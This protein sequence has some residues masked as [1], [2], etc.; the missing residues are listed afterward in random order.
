MAGTSRTNMEAFYGELSG[1]VAS[2]WGEDNMAT[3]DDKLHWNS[4]STWFSGFSHNNT[5]SRT[6]TM[7]DTSGKVAMWDVDNE[8]V[9]RYVSLDYRSIAAV[10][11]PITGTWVT[12]FTNKW[13]DIIGQGLQCWIPIQLPD[14][15]TITRFCVYSQEE[16]DAVLSNN[17]SRIAHSDGAIDGIGTV[18]SNSSMS[19]LC[20]S[21]LVDNVVDN[22]TYAY[23]VELTSGGSTGENRIRSIE[24]QYTMV[25]P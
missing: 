12:D 20:D 25:G 13:I 3:L 7:Q 11:L 9:T 18:F 17:L 1:V 14:G 2:Q 5:A 21:S 6:Y 23:G 10:L 4:K 19:E 15:A 16:G 8:A 22:D 24:I